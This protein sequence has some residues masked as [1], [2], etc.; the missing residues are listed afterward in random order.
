[1]TPPRRLPH[2]CACPTCL[3]RSIARAPRLQRG[4]VEFADS[5]LEMLLLDLPPSWAPCLADDDRHAQIAR[6]QELVTEYRGWTRAYRAQ[7]RARL[8]QVERQLAAARR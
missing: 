2:R 3:A 4:Q 6:L 5:T 7:E 1:M 8:A